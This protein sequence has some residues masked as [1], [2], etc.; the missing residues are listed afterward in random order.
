LANLSA[1][2]FGYITVGQLIERTSNSLGTMQELERHQGHFYNWYDTTTLKP[3]SP[4]YISTVDSGNLSAYLLTLSAGLLELP[5]QKIISDR[6]YHGLLDTLR[7][8]KDAASSVRTSSLN[9]LE[10]DLEA[11]SSSPPVSLDTAYSQLL[12]LQ[13]SISTIAKTLAGSD[14]SETNRWVQ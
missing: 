5:Y 7:V 1:Y 2:D 13:N 11:L 3:L 10:N 8:L 9:Q 4:A 6:F 12:G 14:G